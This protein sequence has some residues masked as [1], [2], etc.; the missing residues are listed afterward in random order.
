MIC[1]D[2]QPYVPTFIE[3]F[4]A[5]S[6]FDGRGGTWT[7]KFT[8]GRTNPRNEE[9]QIYVDRS[10]LKLLGSAILDPFRIDDNG[11]SIT[12]N[13][14]PPVLRKSLEDMPYM[15]GV[16]TTR[17]SFSQTYG[18]FEARVRVPEGKGLWPAVWM[19]PVNGYPPE[20]D[21][22]E[23]LGNQPSSVYQTVHA[24]DGTSTSFR[25]ELTDGSA[26][27]TY[28]TKWT[29]AEIA[30]TVDGEVKTR[31]P[32]TVNQPMYLLANLAVGGKWPGEPDSYTRFPATMSLQFIHAYRQAPG[33]CQSTP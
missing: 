13:R 20:I 22:M 3:D 21:I 29:P 32:N 30:F 14:T 10:M 16:V 25:F 27:H 9:Q 26:F 6:T 11:L 19:L 2:H 4:R 5:F 7:T 15:S 24:P 23:I 28:G 1:I 12:A 31:I 17:N 18:Y 8:W 33:E